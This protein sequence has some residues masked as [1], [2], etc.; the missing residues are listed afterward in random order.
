M[1]MV[2]EKN[3][4]L[5]QITIYMKIVI[6]G[7]FEKKNWNNNIELIF[8]DTS[9]VVYIKLLK[10]TICILENYK[11]K[12]KGHANHWFINRYITI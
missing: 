11:F 9:Q 6:T 4:Q 12:I 1:Q 2:I 7:D 3:S 5:S 8:N 10:W